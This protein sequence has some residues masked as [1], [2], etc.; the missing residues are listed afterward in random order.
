M[1]AHTDECG[2][3]RGA[4][5]SP[6]RTARHPAYDAAIRM[7]DRHIA[8]VT[9]ARLR[10]AYQRIADQRLPVLRDWDL[11]S[12]LAGIGAYLLHSHGT[13]G[14]DRSR[15][16]GLFVEVLSYLLRPEE[17]AAWRS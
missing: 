15:L 5:P 13:D 17:V 2:L 6:L 11:M 14:G 16:A 8:T 9:K 3:N 12:G 4:P 7:L 10:R 1:I